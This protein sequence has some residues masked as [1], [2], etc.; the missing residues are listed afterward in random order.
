L[1]RRIENPQTLASRLRVTNGCVEHVDFSPFRQGPLRPAFGFGG[2]RTP[3]PGLYLSGAG[4]HP[5]PA[6]HGI[7]GRNAAREV[8]RG[9]R[10]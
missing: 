7:P 4:S 8:L 5:G 1:G 9:L 2:Y 10:S 6:V 3:V